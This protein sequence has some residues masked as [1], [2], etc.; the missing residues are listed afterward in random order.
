MAKSNDELHYDCMH[1]FVSLA[2]EMK[3]EGISDKIVSASLMT[4]SCL[5]STYEALGNTGRLNQTG[6]DGIAGAYR[7]QLERV[8]EQRKK[9]DE[10]IAEQKIA[11]TA[12]KI[13]SFPE[14]D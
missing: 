13:V 1:R 4:A 2:N 3:Q 10:E 9:N 14:N 12:E 6:I 7:Q 8:Q 5:F 11:E